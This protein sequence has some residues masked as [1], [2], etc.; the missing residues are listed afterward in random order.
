MTGDA[1]RWRAEDALGPM[2]PRVNMTVRAADRADVLTAKAWTRAAEAAKVLFDPVLVPDMS[3]RADAAAGEFKRIA[4]EDAQLRAM[5]ETEGGSTLA[6]YKRHPLLH[7]VTHDTDYNPNA[8]HEQ[9]ALRIWAVGTNH[10]DVVRDRWHDR[11]L[12]DRIGK[13]V[14]YFASMYG[15]RLPDFF[16]CARYGCDGGDNCGRSCSVRLAKTCGG[17]TGVMPVER[18]ELSIPV[19]RGVSG[20]LRSGVLT[21]V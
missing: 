12:I 9:G 10:V 17:P 2:H 6:E 4:A 11:D 7:Y 8:T 20:D 1:F 14:D 15:N 5:A 3:K 13:P 16:D 21:A 19:D 18:E